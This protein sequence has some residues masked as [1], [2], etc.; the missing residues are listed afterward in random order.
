MQIQQTP[1]Y[2]YGEQI[3]VLS[4]ASKDRFSLPR[5]YEAFAKWLVGDAAPWEL[6]S[7]MLQSVFISYAS[8]DKDFVARL[9]DDLQRS[10][11]RAWVDSRDSTTGDSVESRIAQTQ[12]KADKVLLVLSENSLASPW[13]KKE[14]ETAFEKNAL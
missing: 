7:E 5:S 12:D 11:V 3:A 2:A 9:Y 6:T 1:E 14:V 8:A 13:T 10:G 4:D